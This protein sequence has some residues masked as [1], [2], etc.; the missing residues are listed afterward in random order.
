M[1]RN[2]GV[3]SLI[4]E[5]RRGIPSDMPERIKDFMQLYKEIANLLK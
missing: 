1:L 2:W 4:E 5:V 3:H